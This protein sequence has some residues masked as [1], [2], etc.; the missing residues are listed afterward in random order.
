MAKYKVEQFSHKIKDNGNGY[1]NLFILCKLI[2][3]SGNSATREYRIC[4]DTV[5][6]DLDYLTSII[7]NGFNKAKDEGLKIELSEFKERTYL[8]LTLPIDEGKVDLR[9]TGE[10]IK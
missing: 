1:G 4:N 6:P 3:A 10:R 7:T 8:S 2:N 5:H 9:V